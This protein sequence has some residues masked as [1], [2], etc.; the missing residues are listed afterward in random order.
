MA[1]I[2]LSEEIL[3]I[4]KK[5]TELQRNT[6]L[7]YLKTKNGKQVSQREAY[8]AAG[9]K[10][11]TERTQDSSSSEILNNPD[12]VKFMDAVKAASTSEAIMTRHEAL[13]RL[14]T[15]ARITMADVADFSFRE[16]KTENKN[17]EE[18]TEFQTIW[19]IKDSHD[20]DP[21]IMACIK[22][23]TMTKH[24]PKLELHDPQSAMKMLGDFE[25]WAAPKKH[26]LTDTNGND[27][28][29]SVDA[30]VKAPEVA[31]AMKGILDQL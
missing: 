28:S 24:G 26:A 8:V 21:R 18:E 25:G 15:H 9:G 17:G 12:V 1:K 30:S 19:T 29:L 5:L 14:S 4:A 31:E 7:N 13:E 16:I 23:V 6:A 2:E 22:S 20:I 10:A 11:K 27:A 3:K